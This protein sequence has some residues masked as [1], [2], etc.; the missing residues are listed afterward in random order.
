MKKALIL[1]LLLLVVFIGDMLVSEKNLSS[2]DKEIFI[3]VTSFPLYEIT[4]RLIGK[5]IKVKKLIPFGVETHTYVPSVKTMTEISNAQLFL[6]NGLGMEPWIKKEYP[7]AI[8]MSQFIELNKIEGT[9]EEEDEHDGEHH[10]DHEGVDPHY[11]L[12]IENMVRMTTVLSERLALIF[13]QHKAAMQANAKTYI[14]ELGV[15]Q[16]EYSKTLGLCSRKEIVVNHNAF[17]YLAKKYNFSVH[18]V[19]G[20]SPDEQVSA[21]KM[22][23]ITDLVIEEGIKTIF[24]ESFISPKVSQT[25]SQEAG[26]QVQSLQPLANVTEDEAKIGYIGLMRENLHKLAGAMECL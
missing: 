13:P 11:W 7:N 1:V 4:N 6:F 15:L 18:S 10:H 2:E 22:K 9:H 8:D 24:F 17:G 23:E 21:K 14:T 12:E 16:D 25:I 5:E 3:S 26:V 20:L 19:T